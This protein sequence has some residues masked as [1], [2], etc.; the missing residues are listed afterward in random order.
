VKAGAEAAAG[1]LPTLQYHEI[2]GYGQMKTTVEIADSL[3]A[4]ARALAH[5]RGITMRQLIEDG[6]RASL[7]QHRNRPV[8]FHL[9]DGSFPG[10][11]RDPDLGWADIRKMI[12]EGRG[13]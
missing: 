4:E 3:F 11:G 7:R 1:R 12:Y 6:L 8:R 2:W 5:R 9:K 13:E 10:E